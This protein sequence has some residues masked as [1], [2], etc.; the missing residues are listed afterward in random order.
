M[1]S[2]KYY[3]TFPDVNY[4]IWHLLSRFMFV[5]N[6]VETW[7]L[8]ISHQQVSNIYLSDWIL[9]VYSVWSN[10]LFY[11][12][13]LF[14]KC[15]SFSSKWLYNVS[16]FYEIK[17]F[18]WYGQSYVSNWICIMA[19]YRVC[20]NDQCWWQ[21]V[22]TNV[23]ICKDL[24]IIKMD[25]GKFR[26]RGIWKV[27]WYILPFVLRGP[28]VIQFWFRSDIRPVVDIGELFR[29]KEVAAL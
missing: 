15:T 23:V 17:T 26:R 28:L 6:E 24:C 14:K 21:L 10:N 8:G 2:C 13:A 5:E 20:F 7:Y 11:L 27:Q 25:L 9:E 1:H 22:L 29:L 18:H 4:R 16:P 3:S 12:V 19:R